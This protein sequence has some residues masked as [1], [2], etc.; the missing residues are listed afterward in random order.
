MK[1]T[2]LI[3]EDGLA[4]RV[5]SSWVAEGVDRLIL[6]HY[7]P[8]VRGCKTANQGDKLQTGKGLCPFGPVSGEI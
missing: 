7:I 2:I 4:K 6:S 5:L 8:F 1:D 3:C